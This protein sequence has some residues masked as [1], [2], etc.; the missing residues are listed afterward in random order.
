MAVLFAAA[1]YA[2]K[3]AVDV[4]EVRFE[5]K[6]CSDKTPK[7]VIIFNAGEEPHEYPLTLKDGRWVWEA[8]PTLYASTGNIYARAGFAD[9]D[10]DCNTPADFNSQ[11]EQRVMVFDFAACS[12][13]LHTV[14][15]TAKKPVAV[16]YS[17]YVP[18]MDGK[19]STPCREQRSPLSSAPIVVDELWASRET[20]LVQLA[21]VPVPLFILSPIVPYPLLTAKQ[22]R[23]AAIVFNSKT[24]KHATKN[25]DS[26]RRADIV[27]VMETQWWATPKRYGPNFRDSND[28]RLSKAG[29]KTL[30]LEVK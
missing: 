8:K 13:P 11:S 27:D 9:G 29:L 1:A 7:R 28:K 6:S 15:M 3:K 14:T 18:K 19:W 10:T 24:Q 25:G 30:L 12:E 16:R 4:V 5:S 22:E 26:L 2:Q 23:R 20:F 17:R 21:D